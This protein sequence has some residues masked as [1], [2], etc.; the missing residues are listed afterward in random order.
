[1]SAQRHWAFRI[2][3]L[4]SVLA[5]LWAAGVAMAQE[6]KVRATL[7]SK[8]DIWMGQRVTLVVELLAPGFFSGAAV[9]DAPN[10]PG[11]VIVP[12]SG[13]PVVSNEDVDGVS[14]TVQR[15]ELAVFAHRAGEQTIPP[16]AV[17]FAFKR[18]PL[19]KQSVQ[20]SVKTPELHFTTKAPP[21]TEKLGSLISGREL[22]GTE[23]WQPQ[24]GPAK[25]GDAFT[26]TIHFSAPD[27]PG[28]AFPPFHAAK[29][30]GLGV[31]AK[32]PEVLDQ[33]D[34]GTIHGERS[35]SVTYVCQRPGRFTIPGAR[36]QWWDIEARQLKTIEFPGCTLEVAPNPAMASAT[37]ETPGPAPFSWKLVIRWLAVALVIA[38]AGWGSWRL[39]LLSI[40]RRALLRCRRVHLAPLNPGDFGSR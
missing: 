15:H 37:A 3:F 29:V 38:L 1:M 6:P 7:A 9:F 30:D 11:T 10:M 39:G 35:E 28:M 27:I 16:F 23:T 34:R 22:Q 18:Q 26:R 21:G 5:S 19:D 36:F 14:Y 4:V 12:P 24:P 33:S 2:S 25:V 8:G 13:S 40:V 31:Y 20:A 32:P 17:R